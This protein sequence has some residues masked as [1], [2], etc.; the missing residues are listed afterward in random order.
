LY[1]TTLYALP[2]TG[3]I[4]PMNRALPG[5]AFFAAA[6][7]LL[8][9]GFL[10]IH[11]TRVE[12]FSTVVGGVTLKGRSSVG[13][14]LSPPQIRRLKIN[15]NGLELAFSRGKKPVIIT[16][17]GIRHV[18]DVEEWDVDGNSIRI[19]MSQGAGL[20]LRTDPHSTGVTLIPVVPTTIPP[21]RSL[22][23][24]LMPESKAVISIRQDRPGT[25]SITT[26]AAEYIASLP[27]DSEWKADTGRLDLVVLDKADP[28]LEITDDERGGGMN[29]I[30]WYEQ[31]TLTSQAS[32]DSIVEGWRD[33][34]RAGWRNRVDSRAG[35]WRDEDGVARWDDELAASLLSDSVD[36]GN[37]PSQLTSI[38]SIADSA[39][40]TIG[41]L[42]S[43]YLGN[44]IN[45]VRAHAAQMERSADTLASGLD[46]GLP[47][48][49]M[50]G[51]LTTLVDFGNS[52][53]VGLMLNAARSAPDEDSANSEILDRIRVLHEA[54]RLSLDDAVEDPVVRKALFDRYI[55]PRIFWVKDGLWLVEEDGSID[56][57]LNVIAGSLL[58]NE[59]QWNNESLYQSV[60]RQIVISILA[61][62]DDDGMLPA[63]LFFET[64]GDVL[65]EGAIA[66]ERLFSTVAAP[67]AYP[68]HVSLSRELGSGA[69]AVTGAQRFTIRSTPRETTVNMDFPAGSIH[70]LA[71]KGVKRF[72]VLYMNGIRWNGDPNF[73]RYYAGWYYDEAA[74]TLY[75]KIRHRV[76]T[77]T[78]RILYYDPDAAASAEPIT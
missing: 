26:E 36:T 66:P 23:L 19:S 2:P 70:H 12:S 38:F 59:A 78:I 62:S 50:E 45:Q 7:I 61:Y 14:A 46:S 35:L 47:D 27:S 15:M 10:T 69:W 13:T 77:E 32:F 71:I 63:R 25:L 34:V 43:P 1:R 39:A 57:E 44:I 52:S 20:T 76:Q 5:R 33:Q 60:G 55:L 42:P 21:V 65:Q 54:K 56:V 22:E 40:S 17:D 11:F 67:P 48:F 31:G 4:V 75:I 72:N 28:M 64:D 49:G 53:Q 16:D 41:W 24:P 6:Y 37:L 8:A 9:I 74:E 73:Q 29:A 68:R 58:I 18:L 51:S 30:E 3:I